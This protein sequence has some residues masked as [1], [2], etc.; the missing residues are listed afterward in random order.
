MKLTDPVVAFLENYKSEGFHQF[1]LA[2]TFQIARVLPNFDEAY[3]YCETVLSKVRRRPLQPAELTNALAGAYERIGRD[4]DGRGPRRGTLKLTGD[5]AKHYGKAGSVEM[6]KVK[7]CQDFLYGDKTGEL[8][9][10]LFEPD[11]WISI[12][13]NPFDSAGSVKTAL[14]WSACPDLAEYQFICPNVFKPQADS[15]RSVHAAGWRYVVHEM[16]DADVTFDQQVGPILALGKVL[17]LK[18]VT[19]SAG[20]SLHAWYSLAGQPHK[21]REFLDASQ[22]L[23][24][25]PAFERFT[26]LSRL[27]GGFRPGKG[28]QTILYHSAT[29]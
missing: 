1:T 3:A 25:D 22:R 27:P 26:Q 10:D 16:D 21:A 7:S 17:P 5:V 11:E 28:K 13:K 8:L 19:F 24:G 18:L 20:K 12:A 15:R 14:E 29:K 6:L 9:L 23:G 4:E 2:F